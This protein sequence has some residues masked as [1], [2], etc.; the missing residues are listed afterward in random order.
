MIARISSLAIP[1]MTL[2]NY[3]DQMQRDLMPRYEAAAG[4]QSIQVLLRELVAYVEVTTISVWDSEDAL[5][6]FLETPFDRT[7]PEVVGIEFEPRTYV[8]LTSRH[9]EQQKQDRNEPC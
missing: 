6:L 8:I 7:A 2:P 4:L 1:K 9:K 3:F 5:R